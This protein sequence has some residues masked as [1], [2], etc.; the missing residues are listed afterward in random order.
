M[1]YSKS[2][3]ILPRMI[4]VKLIYLG[5]NNFKGAAYSGCAN[6][7]GTI[8]VLPLAIKNKNTSLE[9]HRFF[10]CHSMGMHSEDSPY[11]RYG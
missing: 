9:Y 1:K 10:Q 6:V 8:S 2:G 11:V 3:A 5:F 4:P 7:K